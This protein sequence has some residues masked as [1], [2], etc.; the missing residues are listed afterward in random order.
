M[1]L[2]ASKQALCV[3]CGAVE[4]GTACDVPTQSTPAS[5]WLLTVLCASPLQNMW[6]E[7]TIYTTA[8][9]LPGIL[10]WFEVKSVFMV[11]SPSLRQSLVH[12]RAYPTVMRPVCALQIFPISLPL[13]TW[14]GSTVSS[15]RLRQ[16][17]AIALAR[18]GCGTAGIP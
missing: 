18:L 8:Y 12:S 14:S 6:I 15:Q 1:A 17:R 9:K 11:R 16:L 10:R 7:R 5:A 4:Q 2:L 13:P 3:F